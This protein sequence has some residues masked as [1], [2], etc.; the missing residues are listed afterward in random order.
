MIDLFSSKLKGNTLIFRLDP[1]TKFIALIIVFTS[2][3][4]IK[5]IEYYLIWLF[6]LCIIIVSNRIHPRFIFRPLRFFIWLLLIT[7]IFHS[8]FTP[9]RVFY[10]FARIYITYEGMHNGLFFSFRLFL[11]ILFTYIFSLTTN[12][13]DLTDGLSRLLSPLRKF[14]IP[15]DDLFTIVL[16]ALRFTPT[17]FEQAS[18]I[19]LAQKARGLNLNVSLAKKIRYMA[20]I[21]VPIILLSLKRAHELAFAL[22]ARWYH[23]GKKRTHF[24]EMKVTKADF[25]LMFSLIVFTGGIHA[26]E[27]LR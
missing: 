24:I 10:Y 11:I 12:P 23:P 4:F 1:R 13:M 20:T 19:L 8:L 6:A 16:I 22:E 7:F 26:C 21:I 2:I 17:L 14:R 3:L 25:A 15:V 9:G 5:H 18:K 27:I